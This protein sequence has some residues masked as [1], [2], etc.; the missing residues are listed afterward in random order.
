L[1]KDV[2]AD[3]RKIPWVLDAVALLGATQPAIGILRS[4]QRQTD[5]G[6]ATSRCRGSANPR[7]FVSLI[8]H[9]NC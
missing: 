1:L 3:T 8:L 7:H 6:I 2:Q 9:P 5:A 4:L